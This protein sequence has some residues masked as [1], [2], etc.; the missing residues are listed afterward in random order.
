MSLSDLIHRGVP[1]PWLEGDNIPWNDP[2]FSRRMLKEHL[3]QEHD[4]A[5]RRLAT[6]D[7]HVHF[8]QKCVL[9]SQESR[10][11]RVLDLGCGPGLYTHRLARLGYSVHG[12]DFSP[13]SIDYAR[14]VAET[15]GL[16]C[17]YTLGDVRT[18]PYPP[19]NDLV[20]FIFG[21]FNV[22][23]PV[24]ARLTLNKARSALRP[25]GLL[26]LEPHK[27]EAMRRMG[28]EAPSWYT[29]EAGLFSDRPH[30]MLF[31]AFWDE[32]TKVVTNRHILVDAATAQVTRYAASYQAYSIEEYRALLE[33]CGF[34][35]IEIFPS[36]TGEAETGDFIAIAAHT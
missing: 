34:V 3:S 12:I 30:L 23:K 27:E 28:S 25:G 24:D 8:I 26:L 5:T 29:A 31:E 1:Q 18:T 36:L 19:E 32:S 22:L 14:Q 35:D 17:S 7:R 11:A 10:P 2:E 16:A 9:N 15:E 33:A 4:A 6:V 20:M 21:E 13:A